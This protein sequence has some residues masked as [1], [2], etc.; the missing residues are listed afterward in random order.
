MASY[1]TTQITL[2]EHVF[3][4]LIRFIHE[5]Y[6]GHLPHSLLIAQAFILEHQD[7]GKEFGLCAINYAIEEGI[8]QGLF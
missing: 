5:K 1:A 7:Y 8:K 6:Q 3:N 4:D 2:Q